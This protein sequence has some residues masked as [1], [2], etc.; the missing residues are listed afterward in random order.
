MSAAVVT[1]SSG[2]VGSE[3]VRFLHERGLEVH[4]LENDLRGRF[5]GP[6]ASVAWMTERLRR[7]LPRFHHH[8]LDVRDS[9]AVAAL[10]ARLG[11]ATRVVVHAAAQPSHDWAAREPETDFTVN[12]NGTLALLEATRRHCPD[13]T[14]VFVSTN[15]VYGDT[16]NRLPLVELA[17]RYEL[18]PSHPFAEHGIDE[19]MS[20]D[21]SLHSL[22]GVSKLAAD[23]LVQEYGRYFGLRTAA[24][25]CGCL[26][27]PAHSGAELH[28][29]LAYLVRC[30]VEGRP[31]TIHGYGGKQVRDNLDSRDLVEAFWHFHENPRPGAVYNMGG[32]RHS[33][34]SVLEAARLV[35]ELAGRALHLEPSEV[36]RRGDHVWWISDVRRFRADCPGWS[37]RFD[38]PTMLREMVEAARERFGTRAP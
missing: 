12:A 18:D 10:F 34:C 17:T 3:S 30:A 6:D 16:P 31:Y 8:E 4:G 36:A 19:S 35:S 14:F 7:A 29:F 33:H 26:T 13:A 25:R 32:S 2:L 21:A 11:R 23:V 5:F 37:P 24:F 38:L 20:V 15:K 1:G 9:A 28:G 27:G 22:F